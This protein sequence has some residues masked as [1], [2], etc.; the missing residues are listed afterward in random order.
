MEET[1]SHAP[2]LHSGTAHHSETLDTEVRPR[3]WMEIPPN[4]A[5]F[6]RTGIRQL[7][8]CQQKEG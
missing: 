3:V 8:I 6:Y 5:R 2:L 7:C 4:Q 1:P